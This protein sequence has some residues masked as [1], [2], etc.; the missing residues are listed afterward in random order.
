ML[1]GT[2][3][4]W[5]PKTKGFAS[6]VGSRLPRSIDVALC[7]AG[8]PALVTVDLGSGCPEYGSVRPTVISGSVSGMQNRRRVQYDPPLPDQDR[9]A[10]DRDG[11]PDQDRPADR[12][13][14]PDRL[15]HARWPNRQAAA[16]NN[17]AACPTKNLSAQPQTPITCVTD[18]TKNHATA[19]PS[20]RNPFGLM[21]DPGW[22]SERGPQKA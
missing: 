4:F 15:R 3:A 20:G 5:H 17:R 16:V 9:R 1:S 7:G 8:C 19:S 6:F 22:P 11:H 13:R 21:N 2:S 18:A 12:L 10:R 14:L